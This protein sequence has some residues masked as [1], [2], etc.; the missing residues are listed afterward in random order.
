MGTTTSDTT[1]MVSED[2]KYISCMCMSLWERKQDQLKRS[3][4]LLERLDWFL[5]WLI[6]SEPDMVSYIYNEWTRGDHTPC[7]G[8]RYRKLM[9]EIEPKFK[10]GVTSTT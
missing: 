8:T 5:R 7:T 1:F 2:G 9:E 6:I 3:L 4:E 10:E